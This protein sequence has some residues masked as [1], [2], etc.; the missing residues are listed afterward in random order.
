VGLCSLLASLPGSLGSRRVARLDRLG[1]AHGGDAGL[2]GLVALLEPQQRAFLWLLP[3]FSMTS[4]I[5][6]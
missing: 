5:L 2:Q 1:L 3:S 4:G 6:K